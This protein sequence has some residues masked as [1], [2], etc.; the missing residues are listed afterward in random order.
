[1]KARH[2][3]SLAS[4]RGEGRDEGNGAGRRCKKGP[5]CAQRGLDLIGPVPRPIF[6]KIMK[7]VF[8]VDVGRQ[9]IVI[10]LI[11]GLWMK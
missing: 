8:V 3:A 1:M 11:L 5:R 7:I 9:A 2:R 10:A 6:R 4:G